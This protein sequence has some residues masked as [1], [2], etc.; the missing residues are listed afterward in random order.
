MLALLQTAT[1][2]LVIGWASR[3]N[4]VRGASHVLNWEKFESRISGVQERSHTVLR[5]VSILRKA[6]RVGDIENATGQW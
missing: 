6:P 5:L 3:G 4:C 2:T 1:H